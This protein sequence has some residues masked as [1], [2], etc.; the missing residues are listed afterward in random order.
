MDNTVSS[1]EV[2]DTVY[3][4]RANPNP[5]EFKLCREVYWKMNEACGI[6]P[7][8]ARKA[9][10]RRFEIEAAAAATAR[11]APKNGVVV[12]ETEDENG[13]VVYEQR[14]RFTWWAGRI[15]GAR[16]GVRDPR[17][18]VGGG[19]LVFWFLSR[20]RRASA[21]G[22]KK[23]CFSLQQRNARCCQLHVSRYGVERPA[24]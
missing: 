19:H 16:V 3:W 14:V 18:D 1:T 13:C 21:T 24:Q 2:Q 20:S 11:P 6:S 5:P 7:E 17:H 12:V 4:Y 9:Q 15:R 22:R 8:E 10:A 23:K